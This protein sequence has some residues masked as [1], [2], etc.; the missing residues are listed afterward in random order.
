MLSLR[1]ST[2]SRSSLKGV[3]DTPNYKAEEHFL[4]VGEI[5]AELAADCDKYR[6]ALEDIRKILD[7]VLEDD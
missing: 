3:E 4:A 7:K 5:I 6:E 2:I 1:K